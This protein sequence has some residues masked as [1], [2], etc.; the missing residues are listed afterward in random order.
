[1]LK[2]NCRFMEVNQKEQA[3]L[4]ENLWERGDR[5]KENQTF[6]LEFVVAQTH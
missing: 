6:S 4:L 5:L 1:M 2:E 3:N